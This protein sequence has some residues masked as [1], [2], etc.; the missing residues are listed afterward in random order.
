L[1]NKLKKAK[2]FR[3]LEVIQ[4]NIDMENRYITIATLNKTDAERFNNQLSDQDIDCLLNDAKAVKANEPDGIRIK[5]KEKDRKLAIQLL[6]EFSKTYG[7]KECEHD[8][9]SQEIE[10]IL[11]PVDFSD[12]SKN[13][14]QYAIGIAEKLGA[15]ILL[16]HAYHFPVINSF[17]LG[18]GL[19]VVVNLND[20]VTE[21]AEKAKSGLEDLYNEL[22]V[23][24]KQKNF[25]HVKLNYMLA[26]GNPLNEILDVYQTYR[27]DLIV[28]GTQGKTKE[29]KEQFGS[30]AATTIN[31][32][33]VPI[34]TIPE[35]SK[36]RG[37]SRVNILYAT[38]FD[39]S[40]F[41]AIKRLMTLIY[42]FDVKIYFVHIGKMDE[43]SKNKIEDLKALFNN[44]YPGYQIECSIIEHEDILNTLQKY[45]LDRSIDIISMTTHKRNF[46]SRLFYPS[47]TKK[48]LFQTD[49]PMLVFHA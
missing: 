33:K 41:K 10:R 30:V 7:I 27:P 21:I 15:E 38:N 2:K 36:Y 43:I 28:M 44:L 31:E 35:G 48:M 12:Y 11:V 25:Q 32:T 23:Q 13:A 16:L 34:L 29:A 24:I 14:C 19:S 4:N 39:E 47:M 20:T 17:D 9:F 40:D 3:N 22:L 49:I 42:L 5:V 6:E 8:I 37:I 18:D 45:I 1:K 46:I 26:N